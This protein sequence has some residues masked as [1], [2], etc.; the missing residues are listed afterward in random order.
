[1]DPESMARE[2]RQNWRR[3]K[4][5]K[6]VITNFFFFLDN[7]KLTEITVLPATISESLHDFLPSKTVVVRKHIIT[8]PGL[9]GK[10][11][12]TGQINYKSYFAKMLEFCKNYGGAP[13]STVEIK[14]ANASTK[15]S[16]QMWGCVRIPWQLVV[17]LSIRGSAS[18]LDAHK[19]VA[20][21]RSLAGI[22]S[23]LT[24]RFHPASQLNRL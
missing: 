13:H 2:T 15:F 20:P 24:F 11:G 22:V 1:M 12:A 6:C 7:Y 9:A 19:L 5:Q 10:K 18:W 21:S 3:V 16:L 23:D 14:L 8:S 17:S 4:R